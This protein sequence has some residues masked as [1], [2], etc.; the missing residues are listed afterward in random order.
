MNLALLEVL[1]I[2]DIKNP[3]FAPLVLAKYND[4]YIIIDGIKRSLN[5]FYNS[6]FN[7]SS[8]YDQISLWFKLNLKH[9]KIS[10]GEYIILINKYPNFDF[11]KY[12][13]ENIIF[14][15]KKCSNFEINI[16]KFLASSNNLNLLKYIYTSNLDIRSSINKI[17]LR[18]S[19]NSANLKNLIE[20][21]NDIY[22]K[23]N[24]NILETDHFIK[25]ISESGTNTALNY[26]HALRFNNLVNKRKKINSYK[27]NSKL[28]KVNYDKDFETSGI[29]LNINLKNKIDIDKLGE[30]IK[31]N[32]TTINEILKTYNE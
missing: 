14:E 6:S 25:L 30:E 1:K 32:S 2:L 12:I 20:Y 21:S 31:I 5:E 26:L 22:L 4:N 27:L 11:S 3:S 24:T 23:T 28:I 29:S 19:L 10:D 18:Y 17:L 16:L 9:R 7:I 8:P 15:Y 13:N